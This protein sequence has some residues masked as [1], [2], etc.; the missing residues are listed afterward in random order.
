MIHTGRL[1]S[2]RVS[3]GASSKGERFR[4][5][6]VGFEDL[7]AL[8]EGL[9]LSHELRIFESSAG[10][11]F[12]AGLA[13]AGGGLQSAA[14]RA[15]QEA[16]QQFI[17]GAD[18]GLSAARITLARRPAIQLTIDPVRFVPLGRQHVQAAQLGDAAP[19]LDISAAAS[20]VRRDSDLPLLAGS[21]DDL[22]FFAMPHGVEQVE[23]QA[24]CSGS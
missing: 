9:A 17:L 14:Q 3:L 1:G 13:L 4:K 12:K 24:K 22:R 7:A 6:S 10:Q 5:P 15:E 2:T 18:K 11:L 8:V 23:R 21:G 20:H 19:Q 16:A